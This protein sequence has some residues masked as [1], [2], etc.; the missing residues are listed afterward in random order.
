MKGESM[1][2]AV[3]VQETAEP[4]YMSLSAEAENRLIAKT[5]AV[6]AQVIKKAIFG[7]PIDPVLLKTIVKQSLEELKDY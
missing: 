7:Y 2:E 4:Q 1:K 6:V 5:S 3:E